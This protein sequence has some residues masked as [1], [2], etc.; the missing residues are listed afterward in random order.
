MDAG[1]G[2]PFKAHALNSIGGLT[3]ADGLARS[4]LLPRPAQALTRFVM[5]QK[6]LQERRVGGTYFLGRAGYELLPRLLAQIQTDSPGR[7]VA[8]L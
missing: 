6:D 7:Q 8:S 4:E 5:Q 2:R 1:V 3:Q